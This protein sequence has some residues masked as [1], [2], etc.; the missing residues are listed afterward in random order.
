MGMVMSVSRGRTSCPPPQLPQGDPDHSAIGVDHGRFQP[1]ARR[2]L[3]MGECVHVQGELTVV[4]D[5]F[6]D[7]GR[8]Q[9]AQDCEAGLAVF[10][11]DFGEWRGLAVTLYAVFQREAEKDIFCDDTSARGDHKGICD[12]NVDRPI[13]NP[14]ND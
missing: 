6:P 14:S 4:P 5:G 9:C 3:L 13:F 7:Q 8:C 10:S 12:G 2:R 1:A 11:A